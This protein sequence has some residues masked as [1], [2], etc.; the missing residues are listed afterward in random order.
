VALDEWVRSRALKNEKTGASRTFVS[1][2]RES[3]LVAGYYCLSASSLTHDEATS[4]LRRN[5][6][7]PIPVIL[8]G[9]LA[10]D[11]RFKGLGLG[12][13]LLQEVIRKGV[14]ASRIIGARA[15]VVDAIS[16]TAEQFYLKFGFTLAPDNERV[17]YITMAAAEATIADITS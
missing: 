10:V 8:I 4:N 3:W 9:R 2:D 11:A 6:P 13:S 17:M 5:M 7:E 14:E 16:E 15:L 12:A 1:V